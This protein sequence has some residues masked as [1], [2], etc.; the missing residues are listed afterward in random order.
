MKAR[1]ILASL[2]FTGLIVLSSYKSKNSQAV[3]TKTQIQ[4]RQISTENSNSSDED[5]FIVLRSSASLNNNF[6]E[7]NL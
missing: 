5:E 2:L 1:I 7:N 3:E 4:V 6:K